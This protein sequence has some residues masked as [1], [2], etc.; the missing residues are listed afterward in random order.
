MGGLSYIL[1][2]KDFQDDQYPYNQDSVD[3]WEPIHDAESMQNLL[4]K[5]NIIHFGQAQ[6]TPFTIPPLDKLNWQATSIEAE[7]LLAGSIPT[8]F[9][10]DNQYTMRILEHIAKQKS[11]P[12]IDTYI[13]TDQ[14]SRGFR[15]WREST[16][17]SP[18]GYHL[19]LCRITSYPTNDDNLEKI[20]QELLT[21]QA[22][23]INIPI[24]KGFSPKRWQKV[25]NAM[26]EKIPGKPYLHKL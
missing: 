14:M 22:N 25:V 10:S 16:S 4:Q 24:Q 19:G 17:T 5:R 12:L 8:Q 15:K 18:S 26:I 2:P 1:V 3:E 13:S 23:I 11:I 20:R 6:G 21:A 7:E 9:V